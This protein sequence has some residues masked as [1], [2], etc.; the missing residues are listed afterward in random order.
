[1][2]FNK[3]KTKD[4][5]CNVYSVFPGI[6]SNQE[7]HPDSLKAHSSPL[8][9]LCCVVGTPCF[10]YVSQGK[11]VKST[12][13]EMCYSRRLRNLGGEQNGTPGP[14]LQPPQPSPTSWSELMHPASQPKARAF[15]QP[16]SLLCRCL[17]GG[18][19]SSLTKD[20]RFSSTSSMLTFFFEGL[21]CQSLCQRK[22]GFT[23]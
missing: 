17:H 23:H 22:Y 10:D 2:S 1:M 4:S 12:K 6:A 3:H 15:L 20:L 8:L 19:M 7:P 9:S 11:L 5:K 21:H 16:F 14:L 18:I 13:S